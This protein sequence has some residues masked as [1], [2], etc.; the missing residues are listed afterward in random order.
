[1]SC[2]CSSL[3]ADSKQNTNSVGYVAE[4]IDKAVRYARPCSSIGLTDLHKEASYR[5]QC[6]LTP[7]NTSTPSMA[8]CPHRCAR[9]HCWCPSAPELWPMPSELRR[10]PSLAEPARRPKARGGR[11]SCPCAPAPGRCGCRLPLRLWRDRCQSSC[12][13]GE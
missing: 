12:L 7:R 11:A 13:P 1:M 8:S 3:A 2:R 5:P 6:N 9:S 10:T 4:C